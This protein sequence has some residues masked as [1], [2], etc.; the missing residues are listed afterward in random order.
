MRT[1]EGPLVT[2]WSQFFIATCLLMRSLSTGLDF[3]V[4]FETLDASLRYASPMLSV[5]A[6]TSAEELLK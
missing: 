1:C 5:V 3:A 2:V 6:I 4:A